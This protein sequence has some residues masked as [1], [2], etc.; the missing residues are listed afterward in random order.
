[1]TRMREFSARCL[2]VLR[3]VRW[4]THLTLVFAGISAAMAVWGNFSGGEKINEAK[5]QLRQRI[6]DAFS[7]VKAEDITHAVDFNK[8]DMNVNLF[9]NFDP[10]SREYW[11]I[12]EVDHDLGKWLIRP[13]T[14]SA[15]RQMLFNLRFALTDRFPTNTTVR[16][17]GTADLA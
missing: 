3:R 12:I 10:L 15:I 17:R 5:A 13:T 8:L 16:I 14:A 1:M 4:V 9:F 7:E 2:R 11:N 6:E